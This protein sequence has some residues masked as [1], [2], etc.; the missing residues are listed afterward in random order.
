MI[1]T[2]SCT[3]FDLSL[4]TFKVELTIKLHFFP[5]RSFYS[6]LKR[7]TL[8]ATVVRFFTFTSYLHKVTSFFDVTAVKTNDI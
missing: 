4:L 1:A 2:L 5:L 6:S 7:L 8:P 3:P